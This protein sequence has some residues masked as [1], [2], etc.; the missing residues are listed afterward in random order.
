MLMAFSS[1]TFSAGLSTFMVGAVADSHTK[2]FVGGTVPS[3]P[4]DECFVYGM[5][6]LGDAFLFFIFLNIYCIEVATVH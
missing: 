3:S 6:L 5:F 2:G 1:Y 4:I